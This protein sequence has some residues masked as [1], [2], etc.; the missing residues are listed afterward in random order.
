MGGGG[1]GGG[2]VSTKAHHFD[3]VTLQNSVVIHMTN[4]LPQINLSITQYM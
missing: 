2:M 1:M 3:L 4:L